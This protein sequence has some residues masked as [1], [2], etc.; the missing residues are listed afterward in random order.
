MPGRSFRGTRRSFGRPRR[1]NRAK[2]PDRLLLITMRFEVHRGIEELSRRAAQTIV[3]AVRWKPDLLLC[4]ATGA[5]PT[6]T[7]ELL[8]ERAREEQAL[9]TRIRVIKLDEW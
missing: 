9:F 1:V 7:Y 3:D 6:R 5:T 8:G 4:A 2:V